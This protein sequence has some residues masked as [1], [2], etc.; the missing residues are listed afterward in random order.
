MVRSHTDLVQGALKLS[1]AALSKYKGDPLLRALKAYAL[2]RSG[3][4]SEALQVNNCISRF[5]FPS[6]LATLVT[7]SIDRL[8]DNLSCLVRI[9]LMQNGVVG[10]AEWPA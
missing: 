8:V 9:D 7:V 3:R 1:T 5:N 6:S 2:D 4:A 10:D